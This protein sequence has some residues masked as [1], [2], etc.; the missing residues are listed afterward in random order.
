MYGVQQI[1]ETLKDGNGIYIKDANENQLFDALSVCLKRAFMDI[2]N[3]PEKQDF[4]YLRGELL[5]LIKLKYKN[6]KVEEIPIILRNGVVKKYGDFYGINFASVSMFFENYVSSEERCSAVKINLEQSNVKQLA[7]HEQKFDGMEVVRKLYKTFEETG[8][9][10]DVANL[11]YD[12]LKSE[13]KI[14]FSIEEKRDI[15]EGAR[16]IL[17]DQLETKKLQIKSLADFKEIERSIKQITEQ[18]DTPALV[19][20]SKKMALIEHFRQNKY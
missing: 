16:A 6:L 13:G 3:V 11:A 18:D 14:T 9:C 12:F 7:A 19:V 8:T 17:L 10:D 5:N 2:G 20:K 4:E 1:A 15:L